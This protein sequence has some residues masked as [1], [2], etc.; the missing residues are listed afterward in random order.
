MIRLIIVGCL[1]FAAT[2]VGASLGTKWNAREPAKALNSES[3]LSQIR[4]KPVNVPI[5]RDGSVAGYVIAQFSLTANAEVAKKL[6]V[7]PDAFVQDATFN[8]VFSNTALDIN[9]ITKDSWNSLLE[10][11]KKSVNDRYGYQLIRDLLV[12]D[13]SYVTSE[14]ARRGPKTP[15]AQDKTASKAH[16]AH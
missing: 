16:A 5:V 8:F 10:T 12:E 1:V 7:K 9:N 15:K 13:F 11:V 2:L 14:E 3:R 6:T 4:I